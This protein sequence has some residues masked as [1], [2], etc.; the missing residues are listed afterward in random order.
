MRYIERRSRLRLWIQAM[1]GSFVI[2]S[3]KEGKDIHFELPNNANIKDITMLFTS[4]LKNLGYEL[5]GFID[6]IYYDDLK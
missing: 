1:K 3:K 2:N 6:L 5:P 4:F